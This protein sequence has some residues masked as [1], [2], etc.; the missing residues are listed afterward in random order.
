MY[1][2]CGLVKQDAHAAFGSIG[3]K[4]VVSWNAIIIGFVENNV[5]WV[6]SLWNSPITIC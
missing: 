4:D 6:F 3:D 5:M 1:A 2:K